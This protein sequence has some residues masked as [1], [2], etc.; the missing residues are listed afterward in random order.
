M[1]RPNTYSVPI[2]FG[3]YTL[4]DE[5]ALGSFFC[6]AADIKFRQSIYFCVM[7]CPILLLEVN[8]PLLM[9]KF[10]WRMI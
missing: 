6:T 10:M 5:D 3:L 4:T 7:F 9:E 8:I 1:I 2:E